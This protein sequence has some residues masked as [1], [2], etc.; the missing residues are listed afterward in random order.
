MFSQEAVHVSALAVT[1]A[2]GKGTQDT[3]RFPRQGVG[4][5]ASHWAV[6]KMNAEVASKVRSSEGRACNCRVKATWIAEI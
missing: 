2:A 4:D 6:M 1:P 3:W 5:V